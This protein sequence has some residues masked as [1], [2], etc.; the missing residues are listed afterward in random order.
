MSSG[1]TKVLRGQRTGANMYYESILTP[2]FAQSDIGKRGEEW[3]D[4]MGINDPS[5]VYL[6]N[7][8]KVAAGDDH[9]LALD[10]YGNVYAWGD[11]RYGQ[12]G[13]ARDLVNQD[14]HPGVND[15]VTLNETFQVVPMRTSFSDAAAI[16]A[17]YATSAIVR[18]D[19]TLWVFGSLTE[20]RSATGVEKQGLPEQVKLPETVTDVAVGE[21]HLAAVGLSG[22]LY[23]W[24]LDRYG[25]L[26]REDDPDAES[27]YGYA[28]LLTNVSY[29]Q[30]PVT[31][32]DKELLALGIQQRV[33]TGAT[34]TVREGDTVVLDGKSVRVLGVAAGKNHTVFWLEDGTVYATGR[35][36]A[37]QLGSIHS[38]ASMEYQGVRVGVDQRIL[39]LYLNEITWNTEDNWVDVRD[40]AAV[41][42]NISRVDYDYA[43]FVGGEIVLDLNTLGTKTWDGF[44]LINANVVRQLKA[45]D[46]TFRSLNEDVAKVV[47][48]ETH[49]AAVVKVVGF[50]VSYIIAEYTDPATGYKYS[51]FLRVYG[52]P[53]PYNTVNADGSVKLDL[54]NDPSDTYPMVGAGENFSVVLRDDGTVWTFGANYD[55][56]TGIS[57]GRLG[58]GTVDA[59]SYTSPQQIIGAGM[60]GRLDDKLVSMVVSKIAVGSNFTVALTTEHE[61]VVWGNNAYGQLGTG[62]TNNIVTPT[63]VDVSKYLRQPDDYIVDVAAG[64]NYTLFLTKKGDVY[65]MG[66]NADGKLVMGQSGMK[67]TQT[68]PTRIVLPSNAR[69]VDIST[70]VSTSHVLTWT[71]DV[72]SW[73]EAGRGEFGTENYSLQGPNYAEIGKIAAM[74]D[75]E[76][77]MTL[78]RDIH[79]DPIASASRFIAIGSGAG[80]VAAVD[81]DGQVAVWGDNTYGQ[82]GLRDGYR[83]TGNQMTK[84]NY[85]VTYENVYENVTD[86]DGNIVTDEVTGEPLQKLVGKNKVDSHFAVGVV[87]PSAAL[88]VFNATFQTGYNT[89]Y[90]DKVIT[91]TVIPGV[92]GAPDTTETV[93]TI[94]DLPSVALQ[95]AIGRTGYVLYTKLGTLGDAG[96]PLTPYTLLTAGSNDHG[97]LGIDRSAATRS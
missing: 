14:Y 51:A 49:N 83:G 77:V 91:E 57:D 76:P 48:D 31:E 47:K 64:E 86:E 24:G 97:Q 21:S 92:D 43:R 66:S 29:R 81:V 94:E 71:G 58:K 16:Y 54:E 15:K 67:S 39:G 79:G 63:V 75:G 60:T 56:T 90:T 88:K 2:E 23:T 32:L 72:V 84:L 85:Y 73:G 89:T 78:P 61:L 80:S 42:K 53:L 12:L 7:I 13:V 46:V 55:S 8:V 20:G 27:K 93:E 69:A 87:E 96:V 50:G 17:G 25:Q 28:E 74:E 52:K 45:E 44:N 3:W 38:D 34:T 30:Q 70:N 62:N 40:D 22:A 33:E 4:A 37:R 19:G 1:P 35:N 9:I 59:I 18:K 36:D 11:D 82:L 41:A 6:T 10:Q 68:T 95:T 5:K 65:G 26:G